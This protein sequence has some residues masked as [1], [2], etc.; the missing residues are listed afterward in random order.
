[1]KKICS[2]RVL[3]HFDKQIVKILFCLF[4][5]YKFLPQNINWQFVLSFPYY[6]NEKQIYKRRVEKMGMLLKIYLV[7]LRQTQVVNWNAVNGCKIWRHIG[8]TLTHGFKS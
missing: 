7:A 4:A 1:M 5:I 8:H 2:V 6:H 3:F